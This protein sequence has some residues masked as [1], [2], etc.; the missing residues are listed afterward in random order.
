MANYDLN[1]NG[2]F[3]NNC[4]DPA[5][6][7]DVATKNYIDKRAVEYTAEGQIQYAGPSPF[8]PITLSVGTSGDVLTLAGSPAL[9]TWAPP[10]GGGISIPIGGIIMW[11]S[12]IIPSGFMICDGLTQRPVPLGGYTP[13]LRN[14]FIISAGT[15]FPVGST[16]GSDL[17]TTT[18]M[19]S[20]NHEYFFG[21][22]GG[23]GSGNV[24]NNNTGFPTSD[25]NYNHNYTEVTP[26]YNTQQPYYP[27][28]YALIFIQRTS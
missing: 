6:A 21:G 22:G 14:K 1:M 3:I 23:G 20:H 4:L 13:D 7:Q 18:Q 25:T 19:P 26:A 2:Q 15:S 12:P 10:T 28:Y 16:G 5:L 11:E 8:L 9:P 24:G 27:P 17:I